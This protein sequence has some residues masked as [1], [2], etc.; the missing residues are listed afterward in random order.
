[1][2]RARLLASR[3]RKSCWRIL[4]RAAILLFHPEPD[5]F[6]TG[7]SIKIGFFENDSELRY[8][9][10]ITGDLFAQADWTLD[11]ILTKYLKATVSYEGIQRI[12]T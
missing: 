4:K 8:H 11:L 9:D 10:G 6:G 3:A 12:E 7:G 2:T 1:M 5:R